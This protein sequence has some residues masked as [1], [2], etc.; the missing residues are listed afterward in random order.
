MPPPTTWSITIVGTVYDASV[1]PG[2]PIANAQVTF[3]R[4]SISINSETQRAVTDAQGKYRISMMMHDTDQVRI[5]VQASGF[6]PYTNT[7]GG[8]SFFPSGD[9]RVDLGLTPVK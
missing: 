2:K 7:R 9:H 8:V 4:N 6:N 5:T 3:A 1:G